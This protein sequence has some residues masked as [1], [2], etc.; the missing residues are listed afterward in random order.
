M[1]KK[2]MFEMTINILA[3]TDASEKDELIA[4][5]Q[6]EIELL[7]HKR[8]TSKG[9]TKTQKENEVIM[10]QILDALGTFETPVT[11]TEL[12]AGGAGLAGFTNQKVSALLRKL[13]EGGKVTKVIEGKKAK[14][15]L[16]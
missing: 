13:V 10:A 9:M 7:N 14:F 12:I 4:G 3:E 16:A 5:L 6:H 15:A 2:E 11:V 8:S 1:T